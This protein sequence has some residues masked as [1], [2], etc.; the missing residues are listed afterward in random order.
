MPRPGYEQMWF[1]NSDGNIYVEPQDGGTLNPIAADFATAAHNHDEAYEPIVVPEP[2][3][4]EPTGGTTVD[5]EARAAINEIIAALVSLGFLL[6]CS[7]SS[8]EGE[9]ESSSSEGE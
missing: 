7:S 4:E 8:S 5:T 6:E 9:G 2:C 1:C 3:I